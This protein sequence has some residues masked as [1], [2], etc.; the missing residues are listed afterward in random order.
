MQ[1]YRDIVL[2]DRQVQNNM[3]FRAV[4]NFLLISLQIINLIISNVS[5]EK[6]SDA[7][8]I[9][10][11]IFI[12]LFLIQFFVGTIK[13]CFNYSIIRSIL[14]ILVL[15]FIII[16]PIEISASDNK[17]KRLTETFENMPFLFLYLSSVCIVFYHHYHIIAYESMLETYRTVQNMPTPIIPMPNNIPIN[18]SVVNDVGDENAV[19]EVNIVP[20]QIEEKKVVVTYNMI[21]DAM[22]SVCATDFKDAECSICLNNFELNTI[23]KTLPC[24]H[25]FHEDCINEWFQ[26]SDICPIC[27]KDNISISM[28]ENFTED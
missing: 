20:N 14:V 19:V 6:Y 5:H 23:I 8:Y 11:G 28:N 1:N 17:I 4:C 7:F 9:Y 3:G 16:E 27:K 25:K 2:N 18:V 21:D 26:H 24:F 12:A 15:I 10:R 13:I 22:I